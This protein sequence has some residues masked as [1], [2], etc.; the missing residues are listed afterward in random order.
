[1]IP[2]RLTAR[3]RYACLA[4]MSALGLLSA[5]GKEEAPAPEAVRP[6]KFFEVPLPQ[7]SR[8]KQYAGT[9]AAYD[10]ADLSFAVPGTLIDFPVREGGQLT[11]AEIVGRLDD[12]EYRA[13]VNASSSEMQLQQTQ[14]DS[15]KRLYEQGVLSKD[16]FDRKTRDLTVA[17]SELEQDKKNLE[18]TVLRAPYPGFVARKYVQEGNNVQAKEPVILL[19]DISRLKFRVSIP[20]QDLARGES[21]GL[22]AAIKKVTAT[23]TLASL[24]G[25]TFD[26]ELHSFSTAADPDTRTYDATFWM[27]APTNATVMPGMTA[28]VRIPVAGLQGPVGTRVPIDAVFA[29][30]AG[31]SCVWVVNHDTMTVHERV[32]SLG[33][34]SA[35]DVAVLGGL[36]PG[37]TVVSA[38]ASMLS[39]GE[40]VYEYKAK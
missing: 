13:K 7:E 38:G 1:M 3:L 31:T 28:N 6:A 10:E 4:L 23:A 2:E 29:N 12:R 36:E 27:P 26:L 18:D 14:Y 20:E 17:T 9:V 8:T 32:V 5:C 15:T 24:P 39:E 16:D 19:Q 25:R 33:E 35:A 37:E 11:K 21:F 30:P 34:M 22:E 40:K